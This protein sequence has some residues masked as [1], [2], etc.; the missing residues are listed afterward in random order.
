MTTWRKERVCPSRLRVKRPAATTA[1]RGLVDL[2]GGGA[3]VMGTQTY[4]DTHPLTGASRHL[5]LFA[6]F[7]AVLALRGGVRF[8]AHRLSFLCE[9]RVGA[10]GIGGAR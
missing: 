1:L 9:L 8:M 10:M 7:G 3:L 5:A 6:V 2:V 4:G